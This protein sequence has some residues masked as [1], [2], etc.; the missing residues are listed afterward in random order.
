MDEDRYGDAVVGDGHLAGGAAAG[1]GPGGGEVDGAL[2]A[3]AG[4]GND[5]AD[6][7]PDGRRPGSPAGLPVPAPGSRQ[8]HRRLVGAPVDEVSNP[9]SFMSFSAARAYL[10]RHPEEELAYEN[11]MGYALAPN[12]DWE[13]AIRN[14]CKVVLFPGA[15]YRITR[16]IV[17]SSPVYVVGNGARLVLEDDVPYAFFLRA[18]NQTVNIDFMTRAVISEVVFE[19]TG[20]GSK[21]IPIVSKT[22]ILVVGCTFLGIYNWCILAWVECELRGCHFTGCTGCLKG[23]YS[24]SRVIV[25]DCIFEKSLCAIFNWHRII[26]KR[27]I[28][29][30]NVCSLLIK[31]NATVKNCTVNQTGYF[32]YTVDGVEVDAC[33]CSNG[34]VLP[35]G[36]VHIT[37]RLGLDWP[38]IE[39]CVFSRARIYLGT[40]S[41]LVLNLKRCTFSASVIC[42]DRAVWRRLSLWSCHD[43]SL[44]VKTVLRLTYEEADDRMCVSCEQMHSCPKMVT[45]I[46][47]TDARED[48]LTRSFDTAEFSSDDEEW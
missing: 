14:H 35:L 4:G 48:R 40:R 43:S 2:G 12:D 3:N 10:A 18:H 21:C 20:S 23:S 6:A 44:T 5:A 32:P 33:V 11:I 30:D 22:P 7:I 8:R 17:I 25:K 26:V 29:Y 19:K 42:I 15:V 47:T 37:T 13:R 9:E 24:D 27:C 41:D 16:P 28:F 34:H 39:G 46:K 38:K 45:A 31:G 1:G 36:N